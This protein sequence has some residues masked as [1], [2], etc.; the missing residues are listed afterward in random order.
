MRTSTVCC[1]RTPNL[2]IAF[3]SGDFLPAG[4]AQPWRCQEKVNAQGLNCKP[5]KSLRREKTSRCLVA[6]AFSLN[7][8]AKIFAFAKRFA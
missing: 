5:L 7:L 2:E 3:F 4:S 8:T 6:A 1:A